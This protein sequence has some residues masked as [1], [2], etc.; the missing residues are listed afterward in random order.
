MAA[1]LEAPTTFHMLNDPACSSSREIMIMEYYSSLA[2]RGRREDTSADAVCSSAVPEIPPQEDTISSDSDD[3]EL[4][5]QL[6]YNSSRTAQ[7]RREQQQRQDKMEEDAAPQQTNPHVTHQSSISHKVRKRESL[8]NSSSNSKEME[9]VPKTKKKKRMLK[10]FAQRIEDLRAYK[11]KH[12][13][14]NVKKSDDTC[15]YGFCRQMRFARKNPGKYTMLINEERIAS[16]DA[17]G[18]DWNIQE[19]KSFE[20]RIEDLRAY[21]ERHGHTNVKGK[22]DK[23]LFDFCRMIRY[24]CNNPDAGRRKLTAEDIASL[25]ALGFDWTGRE[26]SY[27]SVAHKLERSTPMINRLHIADRKRQLTPPAA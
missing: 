2:K 26:K 18:F 14:V 10:S 24:A 15:L 9:S 4:L 5:G 8:S 19:R 25:D 16:L 6:I 7:L 27:F 23:S 13:H 3:D 11:E 1:A 12:G 21:K 20:Q 17:L 22:E